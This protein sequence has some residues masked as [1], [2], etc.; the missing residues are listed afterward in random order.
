MDFSK[1]FKRICDGAHNL[2]P[3]WIIAMKVTG[4][5]SG[6]SADGTD[7]VLAEFEGAST[8]LQWRVLSQ[9]HVDFEPRLRD[10]ILAACMPAPTY[11]DRL[12]RLNFVLDAPCAIS[13]FDDSSAMGEAVCQRMKNG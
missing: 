8:A 5:M 7:A 6:T 4:L 3:H 12:C 2:L 1:G 13:A 9:R 11:A 10:A